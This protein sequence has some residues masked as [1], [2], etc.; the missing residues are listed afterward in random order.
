MRLPSKHIYIY[1]FIRDCYS[2]L[3]LN[4]LYVCLCTH[5]FDQGWEFLRMEE[6]P[7]F[8]LGKNINLPFLPRFLE[9]ME[10]IPAK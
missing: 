6:I 8:L 9:E 3:K 5:Y 10:Q 1:I 4:N 2:K 7:I